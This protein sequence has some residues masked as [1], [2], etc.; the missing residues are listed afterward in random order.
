MKRILIIVMLG[1]VLSG[2]YCRRCSGSEVWTNDLV[3][4]ATEAKEFR[5]TVEDLWNRDASAVADMMFQIATGADIPTGTETVTINEAQLNR[6]FNTTKPASCISRI[7]WHLGKLALNHHTL[8]RD[9]VMTEAAKQASLRIESPTREARFITRLENLSA[10][11]E[12]Y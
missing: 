11:G 2:C 6:W 12:E 4:D 3:I 10:T 8:L 1:M 9:Q 5:A 7:Y